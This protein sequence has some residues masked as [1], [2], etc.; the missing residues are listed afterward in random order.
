[1]VDMEAINKT[2]D[3]ISVRSSRFFPKTKLAAVEEVVC[4]NT[5]SAMRLPVVV[6]AMLLLF[7]KEDRFAGVQQ[8]CP[9]APGVQARVLL[10]RPC[11]GL[12]NEPPRRS[13]SSSLTAR[14]KRCC[15][16]GVARR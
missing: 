5:T 13:V 14:R 2:L 3:D 11:T 7:T 4:I 10:F 12:H 1:M 15:C 6:V 8:G 9:P 16:S